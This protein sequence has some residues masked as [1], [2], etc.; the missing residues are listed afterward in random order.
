MENISTASVTFSYV[1]SN[2]SSGGEDLIWV[3]VEP[4]CCILETNIRLTIIDTSIKKVFEMEN[5]P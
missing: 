3:T 1:D 4:L 5:I 2:C